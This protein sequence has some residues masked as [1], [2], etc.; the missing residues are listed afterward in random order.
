MDTSFISKEIISMA[1]N[2]GWA[3]AIFICAYGS[4]MILGLYYNLRVLEEKFDP[5]KLAD[6]GMKILS[7]LIGSIL[8]VIGVVMLPIFANYVGWAIPEEFSMA[9]KSMASLGFCLYT[10]CR[11]M[12][13]A[14]NKL[15]DIL[16][17][18]NEN[19]RKVKG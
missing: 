15:K 7:V 3:A 8:L 5:Q 10:S 18:T 13:E 14:F 16:N 12:L 17:A 9:I 11:Y 6:S 1:I 19:S 2:A 4:N